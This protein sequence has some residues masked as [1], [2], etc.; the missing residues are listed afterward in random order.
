MANGFK[1][2]M[3]GLAMLDDFFHPVRVEAAF[4]SLVELM[5]CCIFLYLFFT[6]TAYYYIGYP[7]LVLYAVW[8]FRSIKRTSHYKFSCGNCGAKMKSKGTCPHCGAINE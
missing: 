5:S 7:C 4:F 6:F 1:K 8:V 3:S 2:S